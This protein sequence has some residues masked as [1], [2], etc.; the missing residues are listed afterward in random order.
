MACNSG[1]TGSTANPTTFGA[2]ATSSNMNQDSPINCSGIE[3]WSST[4]VY[5]SGDTVVYESEEY[6]ARWWTQ[7]EQPGARWD[8][9]WSSPW[10]YVGVCGNNKPITDP[11]TGFSVG[12]QANE[13]RVQVMNRL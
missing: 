8:L 5:N 6:E 2:E 4:K 3:L 12:T 10:K 7:G 11:A 9:H 1:T 13:M